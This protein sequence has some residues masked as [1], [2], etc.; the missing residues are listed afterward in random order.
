MQEVDP[1]MQLAIDEKKSFIHA[2]FEMLDSDGDGELDFEEF[3]KF[4][5]KFSL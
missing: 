5:Q 1:N 2:M 4:S 3:V